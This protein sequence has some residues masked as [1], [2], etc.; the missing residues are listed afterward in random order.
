M[1]KNTQLALITCN[2]L[3]IIIITVIVF[4]NFNKNSKIV[5]VDNS[6]VFNNFNMTKELKL[7]GEKEFNSKKLH[8]DSLYQK[9][10][11]SA[12]ATER[13]VLMQEFIQSKEELEQFNQ[14]FA[15]EQSSKILARIKSYSAKFSEENDYNLI[16]GSDTKTNILFASEDI[17][18]TNDLVSYIN[19]KYEGL[20]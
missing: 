10:Q 11:F 14:V 4:I 6:Q 17:D 13:K 8:V 9:I 16:I 2:V 7:V 20:K 3:L 5:Y 18:V 12:T 1:K 19:K 15:S